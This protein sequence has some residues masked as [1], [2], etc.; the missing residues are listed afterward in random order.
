MATDADGDKLTYT[1]GGTNADSFDIDWATG[2]IKTMV[3]LDAEEGGNAEYTV[4][5]KVTDPAGTPDTETDNINDT[6]SDIVTVNITITNVNEPP[7]VTGD[8]AIA[9]QELAGS[10]DSV[11]TYAG[12][13]SG[14][15]H[16]YNLVEDGS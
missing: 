4:I 1:L 8:A 12:V 5:V 7:D 10:I 6:N 14:G 11:G 13:R 16:G 15:C 9:F 2:Q 3:P